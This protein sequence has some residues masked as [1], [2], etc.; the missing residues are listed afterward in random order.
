[1]SEKYSTWYLLFSGSSPDGQGKPKY[2]GRT[3]DIVGASDFLLK[4][5]KDR[6]STGYILAIQ[7]KIT[8]TLHNPGDII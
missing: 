1:M 5:R 3:L 2:V 6:F 8:K 4:E 7:D